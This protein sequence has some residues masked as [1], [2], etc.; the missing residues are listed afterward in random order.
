MRSHWG[1]QIGR[2][3]RASLVVACLGLGFGG[4]VQIEPLRPPPTEPV[5]PL[6]PT[7]SAERYAALCAGCHGEVGEGG[8]GPRLIDL[9]TPHAALTVYIDQQ[10]PQRSPEACE[11]PCAAGVAEHIL[12]RFTAEALRC[13][14]PEPG[15][16]R[17]R[18]LNR[19]ELERS[20]RDLLDLT[21]EMLS[22]P[23][24]RRARRRPFATRRGLA[25]AS[26]HVAGTFNDWDPSAWPLDRDEDDF[27]LTRALPVGVHEY[28]FVI[29]GS[30][31]VADPDNP[32]TADDSFGGFNS[33]VEVTCDASEVE[34]D[35]P[36][37]SV[38]IIDALPNDP[39][40][41]GFLFDTSAT[42]P[43]VTEVHLDELMRA[44]ARASDVLGEDGRR[45]LSACSGAP[46]DACLDAFV[47]GR[48][49]AVWAAWPGA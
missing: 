23:P 30:A 21:E 27:V 20:V 46:R 17:L 10:M 12:T 3:E 31:W 43:T 13:D 24:R 19:R 28:K 6:S 8:L 35:P 49:R 29:D 7:A 33:V 40:P 37:T 34:V 9:D 47:T 5:E 4:C 32:R 11:G 41:E 39:R 42:A 14:G 26:V 22:V 44:A 36:A 18:R 15:A 16:R 38:A 48:L 1:P 45:T 2:Y 25:V